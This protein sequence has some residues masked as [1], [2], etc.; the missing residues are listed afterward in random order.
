MVRLPWNCDILELLVKLLALDSTNCNALWASPWPERYPTHHRV[1]PGSVPS[2]LYACRCSS[3]MRSMSASS[4][5]CTGSVQRR[6]VALRKR[7]AS[8]ERCRLNVTYALRRTGLYC[9]TSGGRTTLYTEGH[10]GIDAAGVGLIASNACVVC[11]IQ[12]GVV[13][14]LL[15]ISS[16]DG[17]VLGGLRELSAT[18]TQLHQRRRA[19]DI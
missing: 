2:S 9:V 5:I 7:H 19:I 1:F 3:V 8:A 12:I 4:N 11:S 10:H 17:A 18:H 15:T 16:R 6:D 13:R 14:T